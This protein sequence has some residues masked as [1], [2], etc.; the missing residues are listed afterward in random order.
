M[1]V[2]DA[3]PGLYGTR[4]AVPQRTDRRTRIRNRP[5][6]VHAVAREPLDGARDGL[7]PDGV[8]VH[9]VTVANSP[10]ACLA[11]TAVSGR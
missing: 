11:Q 10:P 5:P 3:G 6:A 7:H 1:A 9:S 8:L 2:P 4:C